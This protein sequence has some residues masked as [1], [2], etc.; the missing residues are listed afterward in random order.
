MDHH[1]YYLKARKSIGG[2]PQWWWRCTRWR[3]M[4]VGAMDLDGGRVVEA[5]TEEEQAHGVN[6]NDGH[7]GGVDLNGERAVVAHAEEERAPVGV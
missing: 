5:H 1:T 3:S 4:H 2:G 7:A 6:L